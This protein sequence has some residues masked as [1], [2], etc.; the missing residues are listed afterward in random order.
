M[1]DRCSAH[2]AALHNS[3]LRPARPASR[4][5]A[6]RSVNRAP[7]F[8]SRECGVSRWQVECRSFSLLGRVIRLLCVLHRGA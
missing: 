8:L 5:V 3:S 2:R 4:R 1:R 6:R 7:L